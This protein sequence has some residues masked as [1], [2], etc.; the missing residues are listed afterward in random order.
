[1]GKKGL[2]KPILAFVLI[3]VGGLLLHIRIHPPTEELWHWI[4]VVFGALNIIV[5]PFLFS[6]AKTVSWAFLLTVLTIIVGT[7][8][9]ADVSYDDFAGGK[10]PLTVGNVILKS[11]LADIIILW[12]KLP[13]ALLILRHHRPKTESK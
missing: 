5:L 6:S 13:I 10:V 3:S 1:M 8:A 11:T 9:M 12:A 2:C 7:L 4:P